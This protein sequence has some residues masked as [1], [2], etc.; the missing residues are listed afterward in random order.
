MRVTHSYPSV[1]M[2]ALNHIE[3]GNIST[4][5]ALINNY[6]HQQRRSAED[7]VHLLCLT[8]SHRAFVEAS[9]ST[10]NK[11][12]RILFLLDRKHNR[13]SNSMY[14]DYRKEDTADGDDTFLFTIKEEPSTPAQ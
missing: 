5:D 4:A 7:F 3:E 10:K 13:R 9:D 11:L 6:Y 12:A 1:L 8:K 2:Q 14:V